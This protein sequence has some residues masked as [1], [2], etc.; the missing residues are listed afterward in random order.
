MDC[1][2]VLLVKKYRRQKPTRTIASD[3]IPL[4]LQH[5]KRKAFTTLGCINHRHVARRLCKQWDV[6]TQ[7]RMEQQDVRAKKK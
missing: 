7:K 1:I 5:S 4:A 3:W 6:I 2:W